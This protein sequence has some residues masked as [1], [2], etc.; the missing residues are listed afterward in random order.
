MEISY[1]EWCELMRQNQIDKIKSILE[2][3]YDVNTYNDQVP[4][5][6]VSACYKYF[7]LTKI[8]IDYGA[9][10]HVWDDAV[11]Y[12][13]IMTGYTA[14][15][16]TLLDLGFMNVNLNC[17]T[18]LKKN[19]RF[20]TADIINPFLKRF[21]EVTDSLAGLLLCKLV[22][23]GCRSVVDLLIPYG[24]DLHVN[25]DMVLKIP[26]WFPGYHMSENTFVLIE[27]LISAG[28]YS[29]DSIWEA[30]TL[31]MYQEQIEYA[32][33][34]LKHV[35]LDPA[36]ITTLLRSL[37]PKLIE[38][39]GGQ[40][41]NL[42]FVY[43]LDTFDCVS[44]RELIVPYINPLLDRMTSFPN[45]DLPKIIRHCINL[46]IDLQP[47]HKRLI[48][49]QLTHPHADMKAV[50]KDADIDYHQVIAELTND[51]VRIFD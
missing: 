33:I 28:I 14:F 10:I 32:K 24:L 20:L 29:E 12:I 34:L 27:H 44:N 2:S 9:D 30:I 36:R 23:N 3:G 5:L 15:V 39:T 49:L 19:W 11:L 17:P 22:C 38:N 35:S 31:C 4:L 6:V 51:V 13:A 37:M 48:L 41:L 8:F 50:L 25:N 18:Q 43:V 42:S 21:P 40:I 47:Y 16:K 1:D 7:H 26:V 46:Q 45:S